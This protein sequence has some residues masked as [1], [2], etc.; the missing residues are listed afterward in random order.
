MR[1]KP[2]ENDARS[3]LIILMIV[4]ISILIVPF[5]GT[6]LGRSVEKDMSA[7]IQDPSFIDASQNVPGRTRFAKTFIEDFN[8]VDYIDGRYTTGAV[9][10]DRGVADMWAEPIINGDFEEGDFTGW[11]LHRVQGGSNPTN[12]EIRSGSPDSPGNYYLYF[13]SN[14]QY[15]CHFKVISEPFLATA[16]YL[17]YWFD[18][19]DDDEYGYGFQIFEEGN[20]N[21]YHFFEDRYALTWGGAGD[22]NNGGASGQRTKA[23]PGSLQGRQCRLAIWLGE[24]GSG[25]WGRMHMDNIWLSDSQGNPISMNAETGGNMKYIQS[26]PLINTWKS[27][28]AARLT[29]YEYTPAGTDITYN[30]TVDGENWFNVI[31][32]SIILFEDIASQLIWNATLTTS[33]LD[34]SPYIDKIVVDYDY[35]SDPEPYTPSSKHWVGSSN[36]KLRWNF[37]DPDIGDEQSHYYVEVFKDP[38]M[39]QMVY[40]TTWVESETAE[41]TV[42]ESQDDGIYYWR[43]RTKDVYNAHSNFSVLKKI[44]VDAT[45]PIGNITIEDGA[46]SVNDQLVNIDLYAEDHGSGMDKMQIISD[47]G[48]AQ[49]WEPYKTE[50]RIAL[51]PTDGLKTVGV[52]FRDHAG[53]ISEIFNDTIY[54]DYRGPGD[55][56]ISSLTHPD[57]ERYFSN[58]EPVFQWEKPMEITGI[59]GYSYLVDNA[60]TSEPDKEEIIT[61][62]GSMNSTI[63]GEFTGLND[64]IWYFHIIACDIYDQWSNASHFQFNIDSTIP[65]YTNL[66]PSKTQWFKSKNVECSIEFE[67]KGGF[68]LDLDT[69][70]YKYKRNNDTDF[71][72]WMSDKIEIDILKNGI[73][74]NPAKVSFSVIL[75]FQEG[76]GNRIKWRINDIS[77]NGP[78]ESD[79]GHV[80]VDL[81]P[82]NFSDPSPSGDAYSN[83]ETVNCKILIQDIGSGVAGD[84]IQYSLSFAGIDEANFGNWTNVNSTDDSEQIEV[85]LN[86]RFSPGKDNYIKWRAKDRV[87]NPYSESEPILV[88]VNSPPVPIIRSPLSVVVNKEFKLDSNGTFDNEGDELSYTWKIKNRTTKE[89]L[90]ED[91]G[92]SITYSFSEPGDYIIYLIVD[93]GKGFSESVKVQITSRTQG[94]GN[95]NGGKKTGN[96]KTGEESG[97]STFL[98]EWWWIIAIVLGIFLIVLILMN[99][100]VSKR[101]NEAEQEEVR[102]KKLEK[103]QSQIYVPYST[104]RYSDSSPS[105]DSYQPNGTDMYNNPSYDSQSD[106]TAVFQGYEQPVKTNTQI[107]V[108]SPDNSSGM[109][110]IIQNGSLPASDNGPEMENSNA[111]PDQPGTPYTLPVTTEST[112]NSSRS[113]EKPVLLSLPPPPS[114]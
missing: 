92:P 17:H 62:S 2:L 83:R 63:P 60:P 106:N 32:G 84:S 76:S 86:I 5:G 98:K 52:R 89:L 70:E 8:T 45:Q 111:V 36:P 85:D 112:D 108:S 19:Y 80:N 4:I 24:G 56:N 105:Y 50:K 18:G 37:T 55:I 14:Y 97:V 113:A 110:Q 25:D 107:A 43:V 67:D 74:Q 40:N 82:P 13:Y 73:K 6:K 66:L 59:K 3:G 65:I 69:I 71:S 88:W 109:P 51:S 35:V 77:G 64:G 7:K 1:A 22:G 79:E 20:E 44:M 39:N 33:H 101:R 100:I 72:S 58:T 57:P 53:I 41:H 31:N 29:Y 87:R 90:F 48:V 95:A 49:Q 46:V 28:G 81:T 9:K 114:H 104:G 42:T 26:R 103:K 16:N 10:V 68:G 61:N 12:C 15:G 34:I 75:P 30:I 21:N 93:D 27:V 54:L 38:W 78:L 99:F 94:S 23:I 47:T 91:D 96:D 102:Q 11:T